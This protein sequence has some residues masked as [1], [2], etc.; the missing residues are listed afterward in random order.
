M[1]SKLKIVDLFAG[2]GGWSLGLHNAGHEII[3]AVDNWAP[4][5][6]SYRANFPDIY[7]EDSDINNLP[8]EAKEKVAEADII[9]GSP[10]C[11]TFSMVNKR[12]TNDLS[13][14]KKFF[15]F[16]GDKPFIMENVAPVKKHLE[17]YNSKYSIIPKNSTGTI[18]KIGNYG[19]PQVRRR[20]ILSNFLKIDAIPKQPGDMRDF[21]PKLESSNIN[22]CIDQPNHNP[23]IIKRMEN[24]PPGKSYTPFG[25]FYK[26]PTEGQMSAI[27]NIT[28]NM[29]WHYKKPRRINI[30]E[31]AILQTF[32]SGYKFVGTIQQRAEQIANSVPPQFSET[33][34]EYLH[35]HLDEYLHKSTL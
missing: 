24:I 25:D 7:L 35:Q 33:I 11:K 32:P 10:P 34:G 6:Q 9:I 22:D 5:V 18:V 31:A 29:T 28:K 2:A 30:K 4:A 13:L 8:D 21:I 16:V 26:I 3:M 1:P 19:V 20:Y 15:E 27:V 23:K 17:A 12:R 14:T